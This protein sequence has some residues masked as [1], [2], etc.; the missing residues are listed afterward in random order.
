MRFWSKVN[1]T[2]TCWLWTAAL[3]SQGYGHFTQRSKYVAAHRFSY[4]LEHGPIAQGVEIDHKCHVKNCVRPEHL[5]EATRKQ[6]RENLSAA[7][8]N[9]QSGVRGVSW[10]KANGKWATHVKHNGKSHYAGCYDRIED[11]E[12]AVIA[13]RQELFTHN[14]EA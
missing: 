1:K 13:K 10:H 5:R 11:A 6:N 8:K 14:Q 9:S 4:T 12:A 2:D 7:Y 3:T